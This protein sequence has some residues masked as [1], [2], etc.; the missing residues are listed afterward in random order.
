MISFTRPT[1][2]QM[3]A[4]EQR[5]QSFY[6]SHCAELY[7]AKQAMLGAFTTGELEV[8][9]R[10]ARS[11]DGPDQL[12]LI[13]GP[14]DKQQLKELGLRG[15]SWKGAE[16]PIFNAQRQPYG[17]VVYGTFFTKRIP[18]SSK[19]KTEPQSYS[20]PDPRWRAKPVRVQTFDF[21]P[22]R[23]AAL[24]YAKIHNEW[25]PIVVSDGRT[26]VLG[27]PF[28]DL[29][30]FNHA[31]PAISD[32]FYKADRVS[33][34]LPLERWLREQIIELLSTNGH[35]AEPAQD[36]PHDEH[37]DGRGCLSVRHD[38]DRD[39]SMDR[40]NE[41]LGFYDRTGIKA[42]WFL[43]EGKPPPSGQA[44][45][46]VNAGHEIALHTIAPSF[47]AM[48]KEADRFV[49]RYGQRPTGYTC[50]G[51]IG[52]RGHLA[53]NHNRWAIELGMHYG[54]FI[55]RC[56]GFPHALIDPGCD[57]PQDRGLHL[58]EIKPLILQDCHHS[59]DL[60]MKPEDHQLEFLSMDIPRCLGRNEHVILMNHPDIHWEQLQELI[61]GL[62][63]TGTWLATL[64]QAA[65]WTAQAKYAG[66]I[67]LGETDVAVVS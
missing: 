16:L 40:L 26:I 24:M 15:Q 54:E 33:P 58:P 37:V 45:M 19:E 23:W 60:T 59:L 29:L 31:M 46:M 14:I 51:G 61:L 65:S 67:T 38:Y 20:D 42:T 36:W 12:R 35:P 11:Q 21:D 30:G 66:L 41:I 1:L 6:W 4:L 63:L 34:M 22:S 47:D 57:R 3:Q 39:I 28:F 25:V 56:R 49:E 50:H 48:K 8:V 52:S 64:E 55:G 7:F 32:G 17:K 13:E 53:L 44:Q 27:F 62:D 18:K 5:E 9:L 10:G 2:D 43:I